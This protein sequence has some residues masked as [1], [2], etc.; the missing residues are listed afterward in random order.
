MRVLYS[1]ALMLWSLLLLN[2]GCFLRVGA[3]IGAYESYVPSLW[4]LLPASAVIEM[5]AVTVF[6]G[7]LML[8][9]HRP[10]AHLAGVDQTGWQV[11]AG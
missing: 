6:A 8:T 9:L 5:T 7:N 3:E 11:T 2:A 10:P 1:P 4:P